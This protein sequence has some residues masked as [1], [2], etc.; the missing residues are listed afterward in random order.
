MRTEGLWHKNIA[1]LIPPPSYPVFD[2]HFCLYVV[3]IQTR[4]LV[5]SS[6]GPIAPRFQVTGSGT[7]WSGEEETGV[8]PLRRI[9][10][11]E[12]VEVSLDLRD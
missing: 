10:P 2:K 6:E 9:L 3:F 11:G 4:R 12:D 8:N 1:G 7:E 5:V